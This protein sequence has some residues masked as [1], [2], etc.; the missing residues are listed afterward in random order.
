MEN[1]LELELCDGFPWGWERDYH[2]VAIALVWI[3]SVERRLTNKVSGTSMC[4]SVFAADLVFF[5]FFPP[6][7]LEAALVL[8]HRP[9]SSF[10]IKRMS[11]SPRHADAST[12]LQAAEAEGFFFFFFFPECVFLSLKMNDW[13]AVAGSKNQNRGILWM[14]ALQHSR[15]TRFVSF[16]FIKWQITWLFVTVSYFPNI[17]MVCKVCS[18][19]LSDRRW[20]R[21][22]LLDHV[23][24]EQIKPW[25]V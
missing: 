18:S 10:D 19:Y 13:C 21:L 25:I 20:S 16:Y 2:N 1:I 22:E 8:W 23:G 4:D 9:R 6:L 3:F 15:T 24:V 5:F 12:L 17:S 7:F 14:C 11:L